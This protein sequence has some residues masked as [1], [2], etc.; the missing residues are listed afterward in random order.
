MSIYSYLLSGSN[1][2][3]AKTLT[4]EARQA[5]GEKADQLFKQAYDSFSV[6]SKSYS[7][8]ADAIY[9]WGFAL[10]NQAQTK[11]DN[12]A[13]KIYEESINQFIFCKSL[14]PEHLGAALDGGVAL[15]GLAKSKKVALG[16]ELYRKARESFEA[17]EK[18]Q[19]GS[20]A[21]NLACIYALQNDDK[22]CLKALEQARDNGLIPD[23]T[24]IINDSDL[25]N[26]KKKPWF[27]KF[28]ESLT[29][30]EEPVEAEVEE[31]EENDEE[32][33]P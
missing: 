33:K 26:V 13:I 4:L 22:S 23:E 16:D 19:S 29:E 28:I 6:I 15:L 20:A 10:L 9:F 17:S 3:K 21:Y 25:D 32:V 31:K 11:P 27:A 5:Q 2:K 24:N 30:D 18:I 8:Y 1:F 12:E 7:N 14:A